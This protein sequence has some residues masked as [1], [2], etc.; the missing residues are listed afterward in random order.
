MATPK[1]R[2]LKT[3][4]RL[5]ELGM[6]PKVAPRL[7]GETMPCPGWFPWH[8]DDEEFGQFLYPIDPEYPVETA[9]SLRRGAERSKAFE[10]MNR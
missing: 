2:Y 4:T 7:V 9:E 10:E 5:A 3:D 1:A 6:P 8:D